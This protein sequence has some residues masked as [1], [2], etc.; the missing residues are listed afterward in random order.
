[1]LFYEI[2]TIEDEHEIEANLY[3]NTWKEM[4]DVLLSFISTHL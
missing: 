2:E 4:L 3:I 1:M